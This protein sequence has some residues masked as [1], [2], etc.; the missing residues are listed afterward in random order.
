[1]ILK[2]IDKKTGGKYY[3][4]TFDGTY[5]EILLVDPL[6]KE[7]NPEIAKYV[8]QKSPF[9]F[10]TDSIKRAKDQRSAFMGE[11]K[12]QLKIPSENRIKKDFVKAC[13]RVGV[14]PWPLVTMSVENLKQLYE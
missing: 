11:F 1:M 2:R 8:F 6:K 13:K 5:Y 12:A 10:T 4:N 14:N 7:S 3:I 9:M